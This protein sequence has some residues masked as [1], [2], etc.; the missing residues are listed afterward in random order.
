[1]PE[2]LG[3]LHTRVV[4]R[5]LLHVWKTLRR[6][7]KAPAGEPQAPTERRS[8]SRKP[9]AIEVTLRWALLDGEWKTAVGRACDVSRD[10]FAVT[11][12]DPPEPGQS[13]WVQWASAPAIRA[14]VRRV[15]RKADGWVVG[16][17]AIRR[18][19]RRYE[20][21]PADGVAKA[22]W[23]G[24]SA[25]AESCLARVANIS[26][27]GMQVE[28]E[29][30]PP[31]GAYVRVVGRQVECAG[32]LRYCLPVREGGPYLIGLQ[33]VQRGFPEKP[34]IASLVRSA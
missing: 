22:R 24:E 17:E 33:F 10:G 29:Q 34:D 5:L 11:T 28:V 32:S 20:R 31:E 3:G 13:V 14:S 7:E 26:D 30:A 6:A 27:A 25:Q 18:E 15:Q 8:Y 1:L 19:K 2:G 9:A 21:Q 4:N 23:L 12:E 16:L